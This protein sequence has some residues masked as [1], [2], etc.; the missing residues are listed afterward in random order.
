MIFIF[1]DQLI[2]PHLLRTSVVPIPVPHQEDDLDHPVAR[3]H[4]TFSELRDV[5]FG[6]FYLTFINSLV[7]VVSV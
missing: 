3:M 5:H 1:L 4:R 2:V 7:S 6:L